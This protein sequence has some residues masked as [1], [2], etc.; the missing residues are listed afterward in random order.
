[1]PTFMIVIALGVSNAS[2]AAQVHDWYEV[3]SSKNQCLDITSSVTASEN[4]E[5]ETPEGTQAL[6]QSLGLIVSSKEVEDASGAPIIVMHINDSN[7]YPFLNFT[8]YPS[9]TDCQ[10]VVA[11]TQH[12]QRALP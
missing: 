5:L 11:H 3:N 8:F 12:V 10:Y 9:M 6:Y 1:M 7:G 4:L 2:A